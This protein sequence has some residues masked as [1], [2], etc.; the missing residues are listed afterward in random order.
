VTI[1]D[2]TVTVTRPE[3]MARMVGSTKRM[4]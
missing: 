4:R 2:K 3:V 1:V